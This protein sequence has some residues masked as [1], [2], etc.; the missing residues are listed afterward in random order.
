MEQ[1]VERF[2]TLPVGIVVR[3]QP[4]VTPWQKHVWRAVGV[5]PGAAPASWQRLRQIG[6]SV[7]YHAA[8][9][10][11][12]IWRK[13]TEAYRVALASEPPCL[14]VVLRPNEGEAPEEYPVVPFL[15][16]ASP[17]EAQDYADTSEEAVERIA[18]PPALIGWLSAFVE[19]HHVEERFRKRQRDR[20]TQQVQ[21]GRGDRRVTPNDVFRS[22]AGRRTALDNGVLD[23]SE[24][25]DPEEG[26]VWLDANGKLH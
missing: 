24:V 23:D 20:L 5:L 14:Y 3:R 25:H 4:G 15:V 10:P 19:R 2:E 17:Y 8:T 9:L 22:P 13:E 26:P 7:E 16:T 12:T 21:D 6:E 11:L 1:T 18:M